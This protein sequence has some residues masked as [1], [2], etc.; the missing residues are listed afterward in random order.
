MVYDLIRTTGPSPLTHLTKQSTIPVYCAG[1]PA[2]GLGIFC[3]SRGGGVGVGGKHEECR[4]RIQK[5]K[6]RLER[7]RGG[8]VGL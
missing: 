6:M 5:I 1:L 7:W 4:I 2:S 8:E 3:M